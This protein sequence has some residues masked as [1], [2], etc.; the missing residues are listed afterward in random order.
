M[1]EQEK[2]EMYAQFIRGIISYHKRMLISCN[3]SIVVNSEGEIQEKKKSPE[4]KFQEDVY[5]QTL[6]NALELVEAKI[7]GCEVFFK[8]KEELDSNEHILRCLIGYHKKVALQIKRNNSEKTQQ[9][10]VY[11]R[12]M[13]K[14][15]ELI[16]AERVRVAE[17]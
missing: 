1:T 17:N 13:E 5:L 6:K 14:A 8:Y 4:I 12:A 16:E 9:D 15:L 2:L 3:N 10:D 7:N 11:L